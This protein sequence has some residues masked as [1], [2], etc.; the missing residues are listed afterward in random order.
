MF[1]VIEG[2]HDLQDGA[3]EYRRGDTYPRDGYEP[4]PERIE[5]LSGCNNARKTP[6]IMSLIP[7]E[8]VVPVIPVEAVVPVVPAEEVAPEKPVRRS[9]KK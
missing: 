2:F 4:A 9:R 1:K 7:E 3:H 6:L 8:A 5:E